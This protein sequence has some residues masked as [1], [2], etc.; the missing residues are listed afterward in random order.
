[1]KRLRESYKLYR[2]LPIFQ[3]VS[4]ILM[5]VCSIDANF[6]LKALCDCLEDL[7]VTGEV[8]LSLI[9]VIV[10]QFDQ[11]VFNLI[12]GISDHLY[13]TGNLLAYR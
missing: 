8:P 13:F 2:E 12:K 1:M 9:P 3:V 4:L 5:L 11:I 10:H 7:S 6:N